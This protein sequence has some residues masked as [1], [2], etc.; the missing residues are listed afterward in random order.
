M[1]AIDWDI[2]E[3]KLA[4]DKNYYDLSNMPLDIQHS[5]LVSGHTKWTINT[6][7]QYGKGLVYAIFELIWTHFFHT[8]ILI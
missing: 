3:T 1:V 2:S 6:S 5:S 4:L 7:I 8:I